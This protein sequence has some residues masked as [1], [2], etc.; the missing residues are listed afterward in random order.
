MIYTRL[1]SMD[2][3]NNFNINDCYF[4]MDFDGTITYNSNTL[5]SLFSKSGYYPESYLKE[6]N[7]NYNHYRPLELDPNITLEEKEKIVKEWQTKTYQLLLKYKVKESDIKKII[8]RN[9]LNLRDDAI[10]FIKLLKE[11]NVPIIISS[12]GI[13][14]FI[15]E[16]L[17]K[18]ECYDDNVFVFANNLEFKEDKIIDTID[19]IIHSMN[20][21]DML[22]SKDYLD[23]IKN[24]TYAILVGDQLSD[25]KMTKNL[26]FKKEISFGFLDNNIDGQRE[27][28][29][30]SYDVTLENGKSFD[31]IKKILKI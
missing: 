17:K 31:E 22:I 30:D 6:R 15:V 19:T 1:D 29:K 12:A 18:Y 5:F 7:D 9:M 23:I 8:D 26:P 25:L 21:S 27:F 16:L 3:I 11:K 14:N 4:V 20:K 28:F 10:E 13:S 2:K 24:K